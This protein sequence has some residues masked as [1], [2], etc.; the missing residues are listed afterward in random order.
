[1][2]RSGDLQDTSVHAFVTAGINWQL[3]IFVLIFLI[4]SLVLFFTR[5]KKIPFIAREESSYSREF[6]MFIG[7]L[8]LFLSAV[9]ITIFT[10]LPV[11]NKVFKTNFTIGEDV[12]FF[13]NR[14]QVF[15]AILLG[16]LTSVTQ[17]L[18]YKNTERRYLV[19]KIMIPTL[20][21]LVISGCISA[22][23][24]INYDNYG[25]GFLAAIH[26]ALFAAIYAITANTGYIWAGLRGK[27]KV[28]GASIAHIGFGMMLLGML[29][30]SAKKEV[31]SINYTNPL[32]FGPEA[33]E[34]GVENLTL[35]QGVKTDM[36]KYWATYINDS[37]D[38]KGKMTYFRINMEKKDSKERFSVYPNL[39][40]ASKGG[41]GFSNNPGTKH[42]LHKDIF[43]YI[44]YASSVQ[45]EPDTSQF[46]SQLMDIGDTMYYSTGYLVLEKVTVNPNNKKYS[47]TEKDTAIMAEL[48]I[49]TADGRSFNA[50][51]VFRVHNN[52]AQYY[53][54]T[55]YAQGLAVRLTRISNRELEISVKESSQLAPF[56]ALK[57]LQFPFINL[58]WLG[59][60]LMV[61]GFVM[62]IFRRISLLRKRPA[63][64]SK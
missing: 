40:K 19:K 61:T 42:Y 44:N 43:T 24:G 7:S 46:R 3:R 25:I 57:I 15:V 28:A 1:L 50:M 2:T 37:V 64:F 60:I 62:S 59:T 27:I 48:K 49:K 13:Y 52:Q 32:N 17:Y 41:E 38:E 8:V 34:K 14:I 39:I 22:F 58:L 26:L 30:S 47:F 45:D 56:V 21:A 20:V 16:I 33:K 51:P 6:W 23:G 5:Y 35:Y 4:P 11:I 36:G 10:S 29:I 31:L 63:E 9:F 55:V 18:K 53:I 12:E 54:D